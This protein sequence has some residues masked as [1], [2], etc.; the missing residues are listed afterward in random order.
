MKY[1]WLKLLE[2]VENNYSLKP[3]KIKWYGIAKEKK[4]REGKKRKKKK[5]KES[6]QKQSLKMCFWVEAL[7]LHD[8]EWIKIIFSNKIKID[9]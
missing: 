8:T 2:A 7:T 4:E 6:K 9:N 3:H 1:C 5:K